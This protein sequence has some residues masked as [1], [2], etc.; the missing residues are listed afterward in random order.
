MSI[1]FFIYHPRG[2]NSQHQRHEATSKNLPLTKK[3]EKTLPLKMP[4]RKSA[5]KSPKKIKVS[6]PR[7]PR[8]NSIAHYNGVLIEGL[9]SDFKFVT[10]SVI[11]L[12]S[13]INEKI[14]ALDKKLGAR[15]DNVEAVLSYHSKLLQKND[16]DHERINAVLE[17]H[18]QLLEHHSQLLEQ[19]RQD[20]EHMGAVLEHHSQLLQQ[21]A[22]DH[23]SME[24]KLDHLTDKIDQHDQDIQKIKSVVFAA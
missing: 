9:R 11:G 2:G 18:S 23:T 10:E 20:H 5:K 3:A 6:I 17:H 16:K 21:N 1:L 19:N 14:D 13:V 7:K 8:V 24:A 15:I 4:A 22:K 12:H